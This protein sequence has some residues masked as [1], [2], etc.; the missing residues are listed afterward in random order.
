MHEQKNTLTLLLRLELVVVVVVTWDIWL[1]SLSRPDGRAQSV[2]LAGGVGGVTVQRLPV[3]EDGL[4]EGLSTSGGS[5]IGVETERLGDGQVCCEE[6]AIALYSTVVTH[7]SWCTLGYRFSALTRRPV[8]VGRSDTSRHHPGQT[9]GQQSRP[10]TWA[11]G[12]LAWRAA[13][14]RSRLVEQL[15]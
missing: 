13:E 1:Q 11:P 9:L 15:G 2:D 14:R 3:V 6:S 12:E 5:E 8:L 7:P 10:R 4:G